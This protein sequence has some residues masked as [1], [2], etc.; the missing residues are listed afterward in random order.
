[1]ACGLRESVNMRY[2]RLGH[3][4]ENPK[5]NKQKVFRFVKSE[6][7]RAHCEPNCDDGAA[8]QHKYDQGGAA[9]L[10]NSTY[11]IAFH[12]IVIYLIRVCVC[13]FFFF[14]RMFFKRAEEKNRI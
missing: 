10:F 2:T 5:K 8:T 3:I 13:F 4:V 11:A 1:M 6:H 14:R 12:F 9:Q 7:G